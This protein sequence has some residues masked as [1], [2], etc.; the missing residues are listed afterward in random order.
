MNEEQGNRPLS[1]DN[2][3][4]T[5]NC[6]SCVSMRKTD[7]YCRRT[8][9]YVN[10]LAEKPC[11]LGSREEAH[12][13]LPQIGPQEVPPTRY[14]ER[15]S[16]LVPEGTKYCPKCKTVKPLSEFGSNRNSADGY[17]NYC[18]ECF[19]GRMAEVRAANREERAATAERI[20]RKEP[21]P[22]KAKQ[23]AAVGLDFR[24]IAA[25]LI[26][27]SGKVSSM[28][29]AVARADTLI[30]QLKEGRNS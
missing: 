5:H 15:G 8:G 17:N 7:G 16:Y 6:G 10:A 25:L 20:A 14:G 27:T 23:P 12:Q 1:S 28:H 18:K 13:F 24:S 2:P 11:W 22:K 30:E 9:K 19:N 3:S 4:E 29:E 21:A 26:Y